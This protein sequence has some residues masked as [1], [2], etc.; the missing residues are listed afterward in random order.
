MISQC[1]H[2]L[3]RLNLTKVQQQRIKQTLLKMS[4]GKTLKTG[5]PFCKKSIELMS[6]AT[7]VAA[8]NHPEVNWL[9]LGNFKKRK[10]IRDLRLVMIMMGDSQERE[11]VANNFREMGYHPEFVN[12]AEDGI[13]RMRFVKFA[14]ITLHSSF[15]EGKMADSLFHAHM[16][17]LP[18]NIR[19]YIYYV[20]IGP[21]FHTLY[22][23]EALSCSVNVV[24]NDNDIKHISTI[25]KKGLHEYDDLF[26]TYLAILKKHDRL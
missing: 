8:P 19:R 4:P 10:F 13:E 26:G 24:V 5:C 2:C 14:A 17:Q 25:L 12:S 1:P 18:M 16:Q 22:D 21:E 6:E 15:E 3:K 9:S 20:L 23:L 11:T 7:A